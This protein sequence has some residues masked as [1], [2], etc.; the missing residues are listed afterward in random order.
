M[1]WLDGI[2]GSMDTSLSKLW[3]LVM[4]REAWR[5]AVHGVAKSWTQLS[6]WT[7]LAM[8]LKLK[9]Y[10]KSYLACW[11]ASLRIL[12]YPVLISTYP[13]LPNRATQ[14]LAYLLCEMFIV[15]AFSYT[16]IASTHKHFHVNSICLGWNHPLL[17]KPWVYD[18]WCYQIQRSLRKG[19]KKNSYTKKIYIV[20]NIAFIESISIFWALFIM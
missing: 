13:S 4:D 8:S 18:Q 3:E 15:S 14:R 19:K 11:Q 20:Q 17:L 10:V 1:R 12:D 6:D 5:A 9:S 16:H 7:E 2:T